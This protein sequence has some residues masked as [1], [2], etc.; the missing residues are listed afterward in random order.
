MFGDFLFLTAEH[1]NFSSRSCRT[2]IHTYMLAYLFTYI[3]T[4][5]LIYLH[6]YLLTYIFTYLLHGTESFSRS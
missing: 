1:C 2:Y 5:I 6:T 3:H 4:Y